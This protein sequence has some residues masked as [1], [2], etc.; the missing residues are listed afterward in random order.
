L[1]EVQLSGMSSIDGT[2]WTGAWQAAHVLFL[3]SSLNTYVSACGPA[4]QS[5]IIT[6]GSEGAALVASSGAWT[7]VASSVPAG[8]APGS[9]CGTSPADPQETS[10][11]A[12]SMSQTERMTVNPKIVGDSF[13]LHLTWMISFKIDNLTDPLNL[14]N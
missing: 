6:S 9:T 5:S 3:P 7:R 10:T 8:C 11:N 2:H 13:L 12:H 1:H 14:D 4:A